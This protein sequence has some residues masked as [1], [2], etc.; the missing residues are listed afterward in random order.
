[1]KDPVLE[2]FLRDTHRRALEFAAASDIIHLQAAPDD[3]PHAYLA[4]FDAPCYVRRPSGAID[5]HHGFTL[6]IAFPPD[7][8][9]AQVVPAQSL[10]HLLE[11][12]TLWHS[13][14][15]WPFICIG[16][17]AGGTDI[18]ELL[19]R[20]FEL[21]T[22]QRKANPVEYDALNPDACRWAREHWPVEATTRLPLKSRLPRGSV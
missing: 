18:V 14:A 17:I 19:L 12:R 1:M 13:N 7:Y 20:A 5:R 11:P 6:G 10:L 3:P 16:R 4:R 8:L 22:F 2:G 21:I 9:T 15:R